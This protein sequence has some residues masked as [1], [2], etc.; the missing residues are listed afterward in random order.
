MCNR[1]TAKTKTRSRKCRRETGATISWKRGYK[2]NM[3]DILAAI[4]LVELERYDADTLVKRNKFAIS[5]RK[6]LQQNQDSPGTENFRSG[7]IIPSR[8]FRA[9]KELMR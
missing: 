7:I 5:T 3:T 9:S 6:L 1:G 8:L 4:G 2:M